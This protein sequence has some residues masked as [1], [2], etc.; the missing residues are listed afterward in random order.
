MPQTQFN[1]SVS[2]A[3]PSS[4][5]SVA[6]VALAT[7]L[8]W[9]FAVQ[10]E[11]LDTPQTNLVSITQT[12]TS[13]AA[14]PPAVLSKI[15][16]V[17]K[18]LVNLGG[19]AEAQGSGVLIGGS[20]F[21]TA[22][23]VVEGQRGIRV[24]FPSGTYGARI[25]AASPADDVALLALDGKPDLPGCTIAARDEQPGGNVY[26]AGYCPPGLRV[27][28]ARMYDTNYTRPHFQAGGLPL[29]GSVSGNSGGPGFN[30]NGEIIGVLNSNSIS[31]T[32]NG[33]GTTCGST[34]QPV[35]KIISPF[36]KTQQYRDQIV[37]PEQ[38]QQPRQYQQCQPNQNC[39]P[40]T[41]PPGCIDCPPGPPGPPG[42]EGP[43]GPTGAT[44]EQG[45][46]GIQGATGPAGP[47]G[48][49]G[50]ITE[51]I[52]DEII[53]RLPPINL[54]VTGPRGIETT[55]TAPLGGNLRLKMLGGAATPRE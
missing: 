48:P 55:T 54:V 6:G 20:Y 37:I 4:R 23:H 13:A 32:Y 43:T 14:I 11:D 47:A 35:R 25:L 15:P 28:P 36:V 16:N 41:S 8:G 19:G 21:L 45:S 46:E 24:R 52:I 53:R 10:A 33:Y 27:W 42:P 31:D 3:C 30:S 2:L 1:P 29:S 51:E 26:F 49:P 44:G 7:V 5:M 17:G 9:A 40:P 39:P 50:E 22:E 12:Q 34:L 18:V 38:R